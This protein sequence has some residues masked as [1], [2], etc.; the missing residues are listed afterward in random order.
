MLY[1]NIITSKSRPMSQNP[2]F[3]PSFPLL[4]LLLWL[5]SDC[6]FIKYVFIREPSPVQG[7]LKWPVITLGMWHPSRVETDGCRVRPLTDTSTYLH[8]DVGYGIPSQ[9][10]K[11]QDMPRTFI[12]PRHHRHVTRIFGNNNAIKLVGLPPPP[13]DGVLRMPLCYLLLLVPLNICC[14]FSDVM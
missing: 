5:L 9:T 13:P 2:N 4:L 1:P 10:N 12:T 6:K 14:I 3:H 8:R 7:S 11:A